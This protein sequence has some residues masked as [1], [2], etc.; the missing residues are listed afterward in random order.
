MLSKNKIRKVILDKKKEDQKRFLLLK[1]IIEHLGNENKYNK[2]YYSNTFLQLFKKQN[3]KLDWIGCEI[4]PGNWIKA[5]C[6]DLSFPF[7]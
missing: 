7:E 1:K 4:T 5:P 3:Y 2:E 6:Q